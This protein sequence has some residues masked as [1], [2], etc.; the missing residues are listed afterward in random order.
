MSTSSEPVG[1]TVSHYRILSRIGGGGMGVVYEAEDLKLGRHVALKFLFDELANDP[2]ALSRFQREAKAASSLNHPNIYT[3]HEIDE[4][5]GRTFIV[6]ELLEGQ[7]LRQ[8][9]NGKPLQI[10]TT[11]DLGFQIADALDAAHGKGI[12]HRDIKP[13]NIFVTNRGQAKILDFGLAKVSVQPRSAVPSAPTADLEEHLTSSGSALG[14]VAY[15]SPEQVRGEELDTRADLFSFGAVLYEMATGQPAFAGNTLG[16]VVEAILN[17]N[18]VAASRVNP[19]A[20]LQFE[21]I[22]TK[23][24][25]KEPKLRYQHASELRADLQRLKR[26]SK[27]NGA[28]AA[29]VVSA[30]SQNPLLWRILTPLAVLFAV[31]ALGAYAYLKRPTTMLS[32]KDTI[33]LAEFDNKTGDPAFDDTLGQALGVSLRQSPYLN[34]LSDEKVEALSGM[35]RQPAETRDQPKV[36]FELCQRANSKA[37]IRGSI[38]NLGSQ[39]VIGLAAVNCASGDVLAQ[40]QIVASEKEKVLDALGKTASKLRTELGES[41]PSVRRFDAP[42]AQETTPSLA[43]LKAFS[44]GLGTERE[45]GTLAA[46]KFYERA[47]ELDPNFASAIESVGIVYS[48]LGQADRAS[49]YLTRAFHQRNRASERERLHITAQ[50]YLSGIGDLDK[51]VEA[52]QEWKQSYPLDDIPVGNLGLLYVE[53]GQWQLAMEETQRS[54]Q[55]DPDGVISYENLAQVFLA[56]ERYDD[57]RRVLQAARAR[58]LDD[59]GIHMN[60]YGLAFLES[61]P[62]VMAEQVAWFADKA[63]F[64][65]LIL[66]LE[67]ETYAYAGRLQKAREQT[68]RAVDSALRSDNKA[69]AAIWALEGAYREEIFGESDAR[70][71]AMAAM[72]LAPQSSEAEE[73]AAFVLAGSGDSKHAEA[74]VHDLE[75]RFQSRTLLRS[76]WLPTIRAQIALAQNRPQEAVQALEAAEHVELGV[77]LS[78]QGPPC[79]YPAYVRGEAFLAAGHG[80]E[81]A[82]EFQKLLDHRGIT[83]GCATRALA[84]VGLARA[85]ALKG[86]AAKARA[87]YQDFFT[88]WKDADPDVPILKEAKAEFAK[89]P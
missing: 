60:R 51:A 13:A 56:L 20:P 78:T 41:L 6:M 63:E 32:K 46:L 21:G 31:L 5:D 88:L 1:Q 66:A 4:A 45:K 40:E 38:A 10:K 67:Q 34:V 72:K 14:T 8:L 16:V 69:S 82:T 9:I 37:Y 62:K 19:E 77:P 17:R 61:D 12:I 2:Q 7:T 23:A 84:H 18:P 11:L 65:D 47:V 36:I 55:L 3:I 49:E 73:F 71:Q 89:L 81:A 44:L 59:V 68:R 24:L 33:V 85:Y 42:L 43:A 25:E 57:A 79:L 58:N 74:L 22:I 26:D 54:L 83:W 48:N 15:M 64:A 39:Y 87:A 53:K 30:G 52:L 70:E 29:G 50:Y 28:S 35:M 75:K 76:Y 27:S 80:T 86:E